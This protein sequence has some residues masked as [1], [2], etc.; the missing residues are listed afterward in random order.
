MDPLYLLIQ[1]VKMNAEQIE[2]YMQCAYDRRYSYDQ[3]KAAL[4]YVYAQTR[5]I[6]ELLNGLFSQYQRIEAMMK[7]ELTRSEE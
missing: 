1:Q 2:Q 4:S 6:G 5:Q 7:M 3:R